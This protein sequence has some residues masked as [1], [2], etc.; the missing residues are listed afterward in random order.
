VIRV[1]ASQSIRKAGSLR[2]EE[3]V[4][5]D[6]QGPRAARATPWFSLCR[7]ACADPEARP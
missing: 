5:S 1:D 6:I 2:K 4:I 3:G 7:L